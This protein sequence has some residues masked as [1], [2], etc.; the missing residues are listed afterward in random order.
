[1][2]PSEQGFSLFC[3]VDS[4]GQN[5]WLVYRTCH[6][7]AAR[8]AY[9]WSRA[10]AAYV[11][12][13]HRLLHGGHFLAMYID[14]L[15][16]LFKQT[17]APLQA[18]LCIMLACALGV[19]LSWHKLLL[20]TDLNWIG[21]RLCFTNEPCASLPG[22]KRVRIGV[23]LRA[24][25]QEG[26][27]VCWRELRQ[28]LGMLCWFTTGARWL[29]P[30][31]S[32]L[33][34]LLFKQQLRFQ[35][36]DAA[37][38][39]ELAGVL[40]DSMRV[41]AKCRLADI[42]PGWQ[43]LSVGS[44]EVATKHELLGL[45][46]RSGWWWVKFGDS[47]SAKVK[48]SKAEAAVARFITQVVNECVP[49][50]LVV[51][52]ATGIAAAD[53]FAEGKTADLGGWWLPAGAPLRP[54]CVQYFSVRI[55]WDDLPDWFRPASGDLQSCIAALEAL[56]QLLLLAC[57]VEAQEVSQHQVG[58]LAIRQMCDN[59]GVVGASAKQL[60]LKRPSAAVLQSCALFCSSKRLTLR[61]SHVAGERN[62][63]A[64]MLSRG[65]DRFNDFWQKLS[66]Q[67]RC[68]PKWKELLALGQV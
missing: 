65:A 11:R 16:A 45:P 51:S 43:L 5:H 50:P 47:E 10:G 66:P 39:H 25:V 30:W 36:L 31:L 67:Q 4:A 61:S 1:M 24:L 22:D 33:F 18:S 37:Q 15:L 12:C 38:V 6:F 8:S 29:R 35:K 44:R 48:V 63:W 32:E 9:W 57:R 56:A 62:E 2:H 26:N 53:A 17:D 68:F 14:D 54:E 3:A 19:P 49:V 20:S 23:A 7:G 60:S 46:H 27:S 52:N 28:L 59:L 40:S 13:V 64:D 55:T 34:H 58:W 41:L 42:L 21:W